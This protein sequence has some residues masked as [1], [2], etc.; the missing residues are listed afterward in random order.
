MEIIFLVRIAQVLGMQ[1]YV[2]KGGGVGVTT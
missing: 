1:G 2:P